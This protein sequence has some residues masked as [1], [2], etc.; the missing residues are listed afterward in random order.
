MYQQWRNIKE[1]DKETAIRRIEKLHPHKMLV[2]LAVMASGL[3]SL[4]L[5]S[6]FLVM[7]YQVQETLFL[8]K[9]F[10]LGIIA[11]LFSCFLIHRVSPYFAE[12]RLRSLLSSMGLALVLGLFFAFCQYFA[13]KE[14]LVYGIQLNEE[15][16]GSYIYFLSGVHLIQVLAGLAYMSFLLFEMW[17]LSLDPVKSLIMTTNPYQKVKLEILS[18]SWNFL[19]FSWL[20]VFLVLLFAI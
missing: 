4:F 6:G 18:W 10:I 8:P 12:D 19:S 11:L 9:G 15:S 2:L 5:L 3:I 17:K 13:W 16:A 7:R 1:S 20:A 14:L